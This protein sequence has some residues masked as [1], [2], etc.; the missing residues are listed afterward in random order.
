MR[1]RKGKLKCR[2]REKGLAEEK[3]HYQRTYV[4]L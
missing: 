2:E 1:C 3:L 4:S